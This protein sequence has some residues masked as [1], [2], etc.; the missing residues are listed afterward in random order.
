MDTSKI[1]TT[2]L[3]DRNVGAALRDVGRLDPQTLTL[4]RLLQRQIDELSAR[5]DALDLV[6]D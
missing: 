6:S 4:L 2:P 5:L 3:T 1:D